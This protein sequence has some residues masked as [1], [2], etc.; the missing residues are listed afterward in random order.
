VRAVSPAGII[1]TV[2]G[3]GKSG[4][5]GDG[6]PA[7]DASLAPSDVAVSGQ[8]LYIA[9]GE[10]IREV[11]AAGVITTFFQG[12]QPDGE[13]ST[14]QGEMGFDPQ[15]I[16]FDGADNLIVFNG[17]PRE[18]FSISPAGKLTDLGEAYEY[19]L[20]TAP[21]GDVYAAGHGETVDRV[22][23]TGVSRYLNLMP[24]KI[25]GLWFPG[26]HTG[27]EPNGIAVAPSGVIYLDSFNGNGWSGGTSLVEITAKGTARALPIHTS[28]L[29]TLPAP[30]AAGFPS[31]IYPRASK[32]TGS[33]LSA[34]P[35][36]AGL[37]PFDAIA[38]AAAKASAAKFNAFTSSLYG[39]LHSSDRSWWTAVFSEWVGADYN[40]DNHTV[41]SVQPAARDTFA[42]AVAHA[43]GDKVVQE[44]LVVDVGPSAYSSQVSHLYFLDRAGHP[45]IYFQ[46]T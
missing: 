34:C 43:C 4:T 18:M 26:D 17:G 24:L 40:A 5:S 11:S 15:D 12:N 46:A 35:S 22:T 19:Q 33:D 36:R 29:A 8:T 25:A 28:V 6:G 16:A 13:V 21:N 32:A 10:A 45:L 44:S 37:E 14:A 20:T 38:T 2:A 30:G 27:L 3:N 42:A 1:T 9:A 39:D 23:A 7:V 31:S 41:L